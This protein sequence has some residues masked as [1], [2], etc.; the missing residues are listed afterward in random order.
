MRENLDGTWKGPLE[1]NERD[2]LRKALVIKYRG[3]AAPV[4]S[5]VS[6]CGNLL[7]RQMN[8]VYVTPHSLLCPTCCHLC[9]QRNFREDNIVL[10]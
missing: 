8:Q 6:P 7:T 5:R 9:I 2:H 4:C 3:H 10:L 1:D